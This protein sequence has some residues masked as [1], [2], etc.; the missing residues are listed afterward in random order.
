MAL[1]T[2]QNQLRKHGR[3]ILRWRERLFHSLPERSALLWERVNLA[4]AD[5]AEARLHRN[6]LR[7]RFEDLC[8][9]PLETTVRILNFL[10]APIDPEPIARA[11]I[12]SPETLGRWRTCSTKLISDIQRV[13]QTALGR[14][15]YL[16]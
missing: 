3:C 2:N 13:A 5:Y 9:Q 12:R 15:E 14:F 7:I 16:A 10:E 6:Y 1:S 11:E 8:A 4:A